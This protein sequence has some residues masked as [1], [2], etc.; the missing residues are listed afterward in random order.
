MTWLVVMTGLAFS[1]CPNAPAFNPQGGSQATPIVSPVLKRDSL[2]NGLHLI[3]MEKR[4]AGTVS[5]HL[6]INSGSMFD[7]AGKGGL[8]DIT[9]GM[10]LRGGGGWTAKDLR[11]NASQSG[12]SVNIR[13]GWD[14]TD[15]A[16]NGPSY[17]LESVFDLLSRI[18]VT[19]TFDQK[20]FDA[21][22]AERV[23]VLKSEQSDQHLR[24][25]SRAMESVFGSHPYGRPSRG[26]VDS[27]S[28]I[29]RP[30][31]LY[32]HSRFYL[33]NNSELMITGEATPEEVTRFARGK[34]GAWKKGDKV[35]ATFRPPDP[36]T[37]RRVI[38]LDQVES[39]AAAGVIAQVGVSR[40][41]EDYFAAMVMSEVFKNRIANYARTSGG[42][43]ETH[44]E[45]RF[46]QG[47][48]WV[49]VSSPTEDL[50]RT[51]ESMLA[52]MTRLQ[53]SQ[54]SIEE[55]ES[56][57]SQ[58][59]AAQSDQLQSA[60]GVVDIVLDMELYGLGRDYLV[61]FA[62]RVNAVTQAEVLRA[63]QFYLKP[64]QATIV[65]RGPASRFDSMLK[66]LGAVTVLP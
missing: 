41:G 40:R 15:I 21:I 32:F 23:E 20:E 14:S 42:V 49:K 7:L 28:K 30:D 13:V 58:L 54:P 43:I 16:V 60:D 57:K 50:P 25:T 29:T 2:L 47:P 34:L 63:A 64:Q 65:V 51:I 61:T 19:P 18:V 53:S 22:K 27:I 45:T 33:A 9:A 17:A 36:S 3:V 66:S 12:I 44:L 8:A 38:I 39:P 37:V 62:D 48:F 59:L 24:L 55:L 10:L 52:E 11:E 26:T 35:P 56:A 5:V 1:L 4:G 6:R 31:L 46:L